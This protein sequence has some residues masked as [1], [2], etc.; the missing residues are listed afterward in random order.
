MLRGS[1]ECDGE[2]YGEWAGEGYG[3]GEAS[4]AQP[5]PAQ[6][7]PASQPILINHRSYTRFSIHMTV[8]LRR[9]LPGL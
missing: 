3:E 9:P 8:T 4:P 6:P 5:S 7:S 2:F 1:R